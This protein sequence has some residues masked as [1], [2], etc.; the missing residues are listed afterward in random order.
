VPPKKNI[1]GSALPAVV[2][3][4]PTI[5]VPRPY[6][7]SGWNPDAAAAARA[8][9]DM[10]RANMKNAVASM[11]EAGKCLRAV[12]DR[13]PHGQWQPWLHAEF[14]LSD[15]MARHFMSVA[16]VFDGKTE[17]I[18]VLNPTAA[19]KLADAPKKAR[20]EVIRRLQKGEKLTIA[21]ITEATR[22]PKPQRAPLP[23]T[24]DKG[25]DLAVDAIAAKQTSDKT[26]STA[27]AR[28]LV[29]EGVV[30][31]VDVPAVT[32]AAGWSFAADFERQAIG[33]WRNAVVDLGTKVRAIADD[34]KTMAAQC[35]L[36]GRP[37]TKKWS[38]EIGKQ[39][40][41]VL[42]MTYEMTGRQYVGK[43]R[44]VQIR[45]PSLALEGRL[46]DIFDVIAR[47]N[48]MCSSVKEGVQE[49]LSITE[50]SNLRD[51]LVGA[52]L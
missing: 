35:T 21:A 2:L 22:Q 39:T 17:I 34:V 1:A 43:K 31:V 19:M 27:V 8:A 9:A 47:L 23:P 48:S 32:P 30:E 33:A 4:P 10:I 36:R 14:A 12:R 28:P 51:E 24:D 7:Y 41:T 13:L 16:E 50:L 49:P 25:K 44:R 26:D 42:Q 11:I 5:P 52:G 46:D 3:P 15:R 38:I 45:L 29:I 37:P 18:S 6:D 20:T 40:S